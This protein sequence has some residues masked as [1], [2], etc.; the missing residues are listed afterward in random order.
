ML[1]FSNDVYAK[2]YEYNV[3]INNII[4]K[5]LYLKIYEDE[6]EITDLRKLRND[7]NKLK[8]PVKEISD[9]FDEFYNQYTYEL[10]EYIKKMSKKEKG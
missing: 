2:I 4:D 9:K 5:L 8:M 6:M 1:K 10:A 3:A 7:I